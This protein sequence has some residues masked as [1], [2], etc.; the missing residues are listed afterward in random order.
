M[1][2][3]IIDALSPAKAKEWREWGKQAYKSCA[4]MMR[5]N[6][7][8]TDYNTLEKREAIHDANE[9]GEGQSAYNWTAQG[10]ERLA[11]R[12][13]YTDTA[14]DE[15]RA[16]WL[17]G[18]SASRKWY[19]REDA[20]MQAV[21]DRFMPIFEEASRIAHAVDVSDIKD[22]F[23]CGSAH[24]YLQR[25]AEHEDLRKA[26]GHFGDSSTDAYKYELPIKYPVHGQCI[27]YDERICKVVNEFLRSKGVFAHTH[28][29]ID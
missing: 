14:I 28:S 21:I 10:R 26:L 11:S 27:A 25:Y 13:G 4:S 17:E 19:K 9:R 20:K 8:H 2:R 24:L 15:A 12:F 16:M 18:Y 23:P 22:G 1:P 29:W 7:H 5:G 3:Q 6:I